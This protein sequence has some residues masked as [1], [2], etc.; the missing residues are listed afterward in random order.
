MPHNTAWSAAAGAAP[1]ASRAHRTDCPSVRQP[2]HSHVIASA[3]ALFI[4]RGFAATTI[5][6]VAQTANVS[7]QFIYAAFGGKRGLLAKVVDWTLVGDDEPIPMVQRPSII[8]I[9]R[10]PS[11]TGKCALHAHHTR[12]VAGDR[13]H[14]EEG[15]DG[16][17]HCEVVS[18]RV[19]ARSGQAWVIKQACVNDE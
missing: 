3:R 16:A 2:C 14:T 7:T 10:E 12:K 4:E 15:Q 17:G 13:I 19:V 1:A 8:A 18:S 11:I 6:D 5:A 9:Q